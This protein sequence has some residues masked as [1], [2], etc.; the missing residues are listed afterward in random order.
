MT[1]LRL[2]ELCKDCGVINE[3]NLQYPT[4]LLHLAACETS[5]SYRCCRA[6]GW[7]NIDATDE[8][9][10]TP[11]HTYATRALQMNDSAP[12]LDRGLRT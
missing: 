9:G 5:A 11:L 2:I 7:I 3:L 10:C 8:Y 4:T 1:Y 12:L 6:A